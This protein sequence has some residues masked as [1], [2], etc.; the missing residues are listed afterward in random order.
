MPN[1]AAAFAAVRGSIAPR[2][3]TPSVMNSITC[4]VQ[5]SQVTSDGNVT[6]ND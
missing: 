1:A 3:F 5:W 6:V 4:S 2:L